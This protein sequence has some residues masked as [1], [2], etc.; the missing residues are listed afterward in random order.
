MRDLITELERTRR[1]VADAELDGA[2]AHVV[3]IRRRLRAPVA[4]VWDALTAPERVARWFLPLSGDLRSGGGF[5]LEGNAGGTILACAPPHRLEVTWEFG[6]AAPSRVALELREAGAE[7]ELGLRH[8]VPADDHWATYGPGAVGVG[9]EGALASF[10][11]FL[12]GEE[13]P[14]D[15]QRMATFLRRSAAAWGA[16]HQV[17]GAPAGVAR[18][19]S[20]RTSAFYAPPAPL[21]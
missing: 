17:S 20:A 4:D 9:W 11:A 16:A 3:E 12:D 21:S 13:P 14:S 10:A 6:A 5:Q 1:A 19:A 8:T 18:E 2:T 15:P 7:T